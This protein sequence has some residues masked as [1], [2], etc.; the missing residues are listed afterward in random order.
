[1]E[2]KVLRY[3]RKAM[4][5]LGNNDYDLS[6]VYLNKA[7]KL[8]RGV[9]LTSCS[10][11]MGITL[12]NLGCYYKKVNQPMQAL[13]YLNQAVEIGKSGDD[14]NSLA[15]TYLNLSAV[16]SSLN[17]HLQ[18]LE[19]ALK[20]I[21]LLKNL[22]KTDPKLALTFV[23]AHCSAGIEYKV[24]H[25]DPESHMILEVGLEISKEHLGINHYLT[26]KIS[27]LI[28]PSMS[29]SKA[30]STNLTP[31]KSIRSS[32][33]TTFKRKTKSRFGKSNEYFNDSKFSRSRISAFSNSRN[34]RENSGTHMLRNNRF[35]ITEKTISIKRH[36]KIKKNK[37]E[38]SFDK[39]V[40]VEFPKKN[41]LKNVRNYCAVVIQKNW[42]MYIARKK[43]K[44]LKINFKISQAEI[45]ATK[46][47]ENLK[48]LQNQKIIFE[49]RP[50]NNIK[51]LMPIPCKSKI[52]NKSKNIQ[53]F[54]KIKLKSKNLSIYPKPKPLT[55]KVIKIQSCIR[56]FLAKKHYNSILSKILKIQKNWRKHITQKSY[57]K[58]YNS[59]LKIQR[60]YRT[61]FSSS[62][63]L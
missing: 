50:I 14:L 16:E 63:I 1:M 11:A 46:A 32:T 37:N 43:Y 61:K 31:L 8:L 19:S 52:E 10:K 48:T 54:H 55:A 26:N 47:F 12:N 33:A 62:L 21:H 45:T 22:Y 3:N 44:I 13:M 4:T 42:R 53:I 38:I 9:P 58:T 18:A 41:L 29:P 27:N 17:H 2:E 60:F 24:L 49:G 25:K 20:A 56:A 6:L 36:K 57:K 28:A 51:E 39:S 59:I 40:Q 30:N 34:I 15:A 35:N 5:L 23:T 7:Q